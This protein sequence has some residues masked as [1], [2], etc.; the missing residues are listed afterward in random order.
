M[1]K[2]CSKDSD[3]PLS[4][5]AEKFTELL[6]KQRE[7]QRA[8]LA[9]AELQKETLTALSQLAYQDTIPASSYTITRGSVSH[10]EF[11]SPRNV[12]INLIKSLGPILTGFTPFFSVANRAKKFSE[13]INIFS[14]PFEKGF[15]A[16]F[17]D[18]TNLQIQRLD[19]QILRD[20]I[21][22]SNNRQIRTRAFIPKDLLQLEKPY[23][24]NPIIITQSLGKLYLIG[25]Q[26]E[27]I[28]R[29]SVTS[30]GSGEVVPPPSV[31]PS[32][33]NKFFLG[34]KEQLQLT[35]INLKGA[36]I[37][38]NSDKI[39]LES[40]TTTNTGVSV[41]L[42]VSET[43]SVGTYTLLLRT[44]SGSI[45]LTIFVG[46]RLP[47]INPTTKNFNKDGNGKELLSLSSETQEAKITITGSH[48][49][50]AQLIADTNNLLKIKD[51]SVKSSPDG[52]SLSA[53]IIVPSNTKAGNYIFT[54][55]NQSDQL[56]TDE[57]AQQVTLVIKQREQEPQ[58]TSTEVTD[59]DTGKK[60]TKD[61]DNPIEVKFTLTGTNLNGFR[62]VPNQTNI[63]N[64]NIK[65]EF[66]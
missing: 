66:D 21:I 32:Y 12:S 47:V 60:A 64:Y 36:S 27:Y 24:D 55:K 37:A 30:G 16:V 46:Q 63:Q 42:A 31:D 65:L 40:P 20:G 34:D 39:T 29:V 41:N 48:L 45:P 35:G 4:C 56:I 51:N 7:E 43:A 22:I 26:I 9:Q 57:K 62:L 23:R 52:K 10:G 50:N 38:S 44:A 54:I 59:K 53:D 18:E 13:A 3:N 1:K 28:N 58:I 5:K 14:N 11:W 2:S 25:D 61:L 6:N 49:Q 17:P 15:E 33:K 19:D 8:L